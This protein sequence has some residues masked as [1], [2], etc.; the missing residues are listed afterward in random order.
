MLSETVET[1]SRALLCLLLSPRFGTFDRCASLLPVFSWLR[2]LEA[3][4]ILAVMLCADAPRHGE[5]GECAAS[6]VVLLCVLWLVVRLACA[7]LL[8]LYSGSVAFPR[9][10][11]FQAVSRRWRMG[12]SRACGGGRCDDVGARRHAAFQA[13][14][15]PGAW[16]HG[17]LLYSCSSKLSMQQEF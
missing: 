1:R 5:R 17:S 8:S 2:H 14:I 3:S 12:V 13:L 10:P 6:R 4:M 11:G 7:W 16:L 15:P 9:Q